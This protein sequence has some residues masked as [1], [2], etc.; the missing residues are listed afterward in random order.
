[1]FS[2]APRDELMAHSP[3]IA[4]LGEL[5]ASLL[6]PYSIPTFQE[7]PLPGLSWLQGCNS[8]KYLVEANI[9]LFVVTS[10]GHKNGRSRSHNPEVAGSNP[11][12]ASP[13][14]TVTAGR[15]R[16]SCRGAGA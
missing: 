16:T 11:A 3:L 7:W 12:P 13:L 4:E 5:S 10:C 14:P 1:M 6:H 15:A 8:T 9:A 2:R